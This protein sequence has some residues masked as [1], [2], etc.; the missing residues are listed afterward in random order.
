MGEASSVCQERI[1]RLCGD[2]KLPT[3]AAE[4]APRFIE[5]GHGEALETLLE[6]LEMEA[7][8]RR[9]RRVTRLRRASRLPVG[10]TWETFDQERL[11]PKLRQQMLE[12]AQGDFLDSGANVLAFG[13]PGAGK[14]HALCAVAHRLVEAGRSVLFIPAYRL[15]QDL[16]AARRDLD[17]P[18]ALRKL[19][20]FDLLL[21][22]DLGYLP[23]GAEE[24][25]VLFTL[26][27]ERY[28]RRSLAITSNLVFS[29][30]DKLFQNPMATA[31]AIDRVVHHSFILELDVPSYRTAQAQQRSDQG[32]SE[33]EVNRQK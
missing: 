19:D 27:A 24:S 33:K 31:A 14:T 23:Q 18:R 6:V 29:E 5:S 22:D 11:S 17:L 21:I 9:Q 10:K 7:E 25:E 32:R 13:L 16:L 3:V 30:W 12:L 20:N 2:F 28:E 8:D 15:A 1:A 26:M 4:A